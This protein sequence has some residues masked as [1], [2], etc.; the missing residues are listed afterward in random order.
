MTYTDG[1]TFSKALCSFSATSRAWDIG[2]VLALGVPKLSGKVHPSQRWCDV[3]D[4]APVLSYEVGVGVDKGGSEGKSNQR[5]SFAWH[6]Y[7]KLPQA[8]TYLCTW[9]ASNYYQSPLERTSFYT[10]F[11]FSYIF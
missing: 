6:Q 4:G 8:L 2:A 3:G 5:T 1:V 11:F 9:N 10:I 7:L